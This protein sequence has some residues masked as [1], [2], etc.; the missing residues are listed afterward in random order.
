MQK[1]TANIRAGLLVAV[2]VS[3]FRMGDKAFRSSPVEPPPTL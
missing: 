3:T 2:I 1:Y